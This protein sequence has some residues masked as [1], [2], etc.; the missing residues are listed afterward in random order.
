MALLAAGCSGEPVTPA[1]TQKTVSAR[2]ATPDQVVSAARAGLADLLRAVPAGQEQRFGF[3]SREGFADATLAR[4]Y[5]MV[6]LGRTPGG[7]RGAGHP[8]RLRALGPW[9]VPVV[10]GGRFR[11]LI[12]VGR[13]DHRL[14]AVELGAAGLARELEAVEQRVGESRGPLR[15][16]LLRIFELRSDLALVAAGDDALESGTLYPL[17]SARSFLG[18]PDRAV[19]GL[20][21]LRPA[22]SAQMEASHGR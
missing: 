11:A 1:R 4:P 2:A 16:A 9:R 13:I 7:E 12:T 22:L 14:E 20:D 3:S 15:R 17:A 10:S 6:T 19:Q 21:A 5:E 18:L 8:W